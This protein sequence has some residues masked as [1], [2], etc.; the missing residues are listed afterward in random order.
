MVETKTLLLEICQKVYSELGFGLAELVYEKCIASELMDIFKNINTEYHVPQYYTTQTGRI[1]QVADLRIDILINDDIIIELK[2]LESSLSKKKDI[3]QTKEYLQTQRYM[4][5]MNINNG[6][7][8]NFH[9]E[10]FDLYEVK[11]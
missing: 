3:T 1:I 6:Y 9:K 10:G 11:L 7:L 4:K 5:L 2:T 8:I